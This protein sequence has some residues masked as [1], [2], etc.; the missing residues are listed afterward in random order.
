MHILHFYR[1]VSL[2]CSIGLLWILKNGKFAHTAF[3]LCVADYCQQTP[4]K[5]AQ[6]YLFNFSQLWRLWYHK[7]AYI[8]LITHVKF[9]GWKVL[10]SEDIN[11]KVSGYGNRQHGVSVLFRDRKKHPLAGV[12]FYLE[13]QRHD[14]DHFSS[15]YNFNFMW[16]KKFLCFFIATCFFFFVFLFFF[17]L[18]LSPS[19]TMQPTMEDCSGKSRPYS[20]AIIL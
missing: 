3:L 4:F 20:C 17:L 7:K 6:S 12:G 9:Y 19:E 8:Y 2:K 1:F 18:V 13:Q 11:E 10:R 16:K 14:T 5:G 15:K